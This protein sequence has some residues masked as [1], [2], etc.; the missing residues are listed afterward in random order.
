M[1]A[2]ISSFVE[3]GDRE[4]TKDREKTMD[5]ENHIPGHLIGGRFDW[6]EINID[7]IKEMDPEYLE[8]SVSMDIDEIVGYNDLFIAKDHW[9]QYGVI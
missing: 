8:I 5:L 2:E 9:I 7:L 6:N 3:F 4:A 1:F